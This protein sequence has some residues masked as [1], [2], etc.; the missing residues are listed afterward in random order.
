MGCCTCKFLDENNVREGKVSG[1]CYFCK[2]RKC[3]VTGNSTG[4][5]FSVMTI[6]EI[7]IWRMRYTIMEKSITMMIHQL[8]FI[9]LFWLF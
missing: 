4:C 5:D 1:C 8:V 9:Y 2:K 7:V 3:Y 6:V